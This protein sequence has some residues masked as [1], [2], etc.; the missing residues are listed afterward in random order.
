MFYRVHYDVDGREFIRDLFTKEVAEM[1]LKFCKDKNLAD[2]TPYTAKKI[3]KV[4]ESDYVGG[5]YLDGN[6]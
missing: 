6:T 2:G 3:S 5:K 1:E 4:K